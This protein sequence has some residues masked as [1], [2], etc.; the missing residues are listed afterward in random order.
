VCIRCRVFAFLAPYLLP[1]VGHFQIFLSLDGVQDDEPGC[2][3][4][5]EATLNGILP[6]GVELQG[7]QGRAQDRRSGIKT[8][9]VVHNGEQATIKRL[10][11]PA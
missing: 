4:G 8:P 5:F 11:F 7:I 10:G 9:E 3:T 6:H 1:E 2:L